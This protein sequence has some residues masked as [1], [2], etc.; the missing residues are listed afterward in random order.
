MRANIKY[1]LSLVLVLH[2]SILNGQTPV[3]Y[4]DSISVQTN[5]PDSR[6]YTTD[7]IVTYS[8]HSISGYVDSTSIPANV[9]EL[10]NY[11]A[12]SIGNSA[13][14][15]PVQTN[16][17]DSLSCITDSVNNSVVDSLETPV[18]SISV[19]V[20]T[21]DSLSYITDSVDNSV[22]D[23]IENPVDSVSVQVITPDSLSYTADSIDNIVVENTDNIEFDNINTLH[24]SLDESVSLPPLEVFFQ[25]I[26]EHPS[27]MI[28]QT[29]RDEE[30]AKLSQ[31][32]IEWLDYLR[33][34]GNYQ[35]GKNNMLIYDINNAGS[36]TGFT[37][38]AINSY[39]VGV[40]LSIPLGDPFVQAKKT[41]AQKAVVER[42]TYQQ[43]LAI[44]ER[45][46][47][48]LQAYNAVIRELATLKTKSDAIAIYNAQIKIAEQQF[49]SGDLSSRELSQEYSR[50]SDVL[51]RY[52]SGK[53]ALYE[54]ITLLEMLSGVKV[55]NQDKE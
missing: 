16:I 9:L 28:Y 44:E 20:I 46:L 21:S 6:N 54:S 25:K 49:I 24:L 41:K 15:I 4:A 36:L 42:I 27:V 48:I 38:Q 10:Q 5:T 32:R 8:I 47:L 22:V 39:G 2:L 19:Q 13:D 7:S 26:H 1:T 18:D 50:R 11:T 55:L 53:A 3:L 43:K 51:V 40:A 29:F 31:R 14:S 17:P 23:S 35:Y 45:K 37:D 33:L 12:D 30:R 34:V 52:E